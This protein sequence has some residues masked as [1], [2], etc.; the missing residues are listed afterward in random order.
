MA[1][2]AGS[3]VPAEV[4]RFDALAGQWWDPAGP[5]LPLHQ[6][7][8]ARIGWIAE[9]LGT[10]FGAAPVRLLDVGCGAGLAAEALARRGH[11][12]LG[13]DAAGAALAAAEAHAAGQGLPLAYRG[14]TAE[15]LVAEGARFPAVTALEVLEHVADPAAFLRTLAR[16]LEPGGL[17]FVS[18]VNRTGR[19]LL[20][21]KLGAEYVLRW[22]PAG[23]HDWRRFVTPA[24]L[25]TY[26]R[27]AGLRLA[28]IAGLLPE[29]LRGGW[30]TGR[31]V[32]VNY[33]AM[34]EG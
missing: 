1:E 22:L 4:A 7:N 21:A 2:Q 19:S 3:I 15:A 28:D 9:R 24:E 30:R 12:V 23:T 20:T 10:R 11:Q 14:A 17:L 34:A 25:D 16:L 29:K 32:G 33:I 6:M 18:T 27:A 26:L 5:M 13:I 8:P 31:D